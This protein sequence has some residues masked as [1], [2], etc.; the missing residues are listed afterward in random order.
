MVHTTKEF[1]TALLNDK[2]DWLERATITLE[3]GQVL[4]ITNEDIWQ[5]GF[6]IEDAISD[7]NTFSALGGVVI[8]KATLVLSNIYDKFSEYDFTYATVK[9]RVGLQL[10]QE[11]EMLDKGIYVVDNAIYNGSIITL[12]CYDYMARFDKP[13]TESTLQYP[14]TLDTIVRDACTTCKVPQATFDFPHKTF[15]VQ[16]RPDDEAVT[17]RSVLMWAAEIAGCFARIS[18]EGKLELAWFST[19]SSETIEPRLDGGT[20]DDGSPTY[21]SGD[22]ADGGSFNPWN[23]GD[24]YDVGTFED[25][26]TIHRINSTY[27]EDIATDDTVI[28]GVSILVKTKDENNQDALVEFRAGVEGFVI[29]IDDNDFLT[30]SNAQ[31]VADWLYEQLGGVRFR[32]AITQHPSDPSIEAGDMAILT[33]RKGN[34]YTMLVTRTVFSAGEAQTTASASESVPRNSA[35]RFTEA[36]KN[37]VALRKQVIKERTAREI[38]QEELAAAIAAKNG[39]YTTEEEGSGGGTTFYLHNHPNLSDSNIVWRMTADAFAVTNDYQGDETVWNAGLTVDGNLIANILSVYGINADWI[40]AGQLNI[41]D[42][43]GNETFFADTETGVVR[44]AASQFSLTGKTIPEIAQDSIEVGGRNLLRT[45]PKASNPTAYNAYQLNLVEK[46]VAGQTYTLQFWGIELDAG[47]SGIAVFWGGGG[48][49]IYNTAHLLH[50]DENGY[51]CATFTITEAQ[52]SH[53]QAANLWLNIY[54]VPRNHTGSSLTIE[55]WKLE[56]GNT[57]SD[58]TES[59]EDVF[60]YSDAQLN[61]FAQTVQA[62]I[63]DLQNQIDGVVDTYY[64]DYEPTVNNYPAHDWVVA[65]TE[66]EH[67]GDLFLDTS[68][69]KS[70]RWLMENNVWKWKEIPDTAAAQ[71]LQVAQHAQDTADGK[72]RVFVAQPTTEQAYDAGDLWVNATYG[73]TFSND[74]L[75]CVTPK[76]EGAAFN[77]NHWQL[78]SK[79]TDDSSLDAFIAGDYADDID[80]IGKQLDLR[81]QTYYQTSDPSTSWDTAAK[82]EHKGDLWYNSTSTV[83]KY[84]RWSGTAWQELT[85]TPPSAVVT[86]INNKGQIFTSEPVPPYARGDLWFGGATSDVLTCIKS[87]SSGSYVASDW[88]KL[89]KYTDDTAANQAQWTASS[90]LENANTA[91]NIAEAHYGTSDT[92]SDEQTKD[93]TCEGFTLYKGAQITVK[94]TNS[95]TSKYNVKLN[96][97]STGAKFVMNG[98]GKYVSAS[99][100]LYNWNTGNQRR[101]FVYDG[102]YWQMAPELSTYD[103]YLGKETTFNKLTDNGKQQAI[104]MDENGDLYINA[105]YIKAGVMSAELIS[106]GTLRLGYERALAGGGNIRMYNTNKSLVGWWDNTGLYIGDQVDGSVAQGWVEPNFAVLANGDVHIK[107]GSI[108]LGSGN[109]I[110]ASDGTLTIRKGSINIGSGKF[111]VSTAGALTATSATIT[112]AVYATSGTFGSASASKKITIGTNTSNASIYYGMSSLSSSSNGFYLGT[113]GIALGGGKFKVTSSGYAT[114]KG[115][116][117]SSGSGYYAELSPLGELK[118]G[119]GSSQYGYI[120]YAATGTDEPTGATL[121]GIQMQAT[122]LLR[123]SSPRISVAA[124]SNVSSTAY[125]GWNGTVACNL[126]SSGG[127]MYWDNRTVINGIIT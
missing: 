124:S 81:A 126:R 74:V 105:S 71:A 18:R 14:A 10:S 19:A 47:A 111:I 86:T 41:S 80:A 93:V 33:D 95:N 92:P 31:Q 27:S 48:N 26:S 23:V 101:T 51:I 5:G 110:A 82:A 120:D 91:R 88:K 40:N 117:R 1:K 4:N 49:G 6:T 29:Y 122:G 72:R 9:M 83:Q 76:A 25:Q 107:S 118:G 20:F 99:T 53:A 8:N 66:A 43:S 90:A 58:Y 89:N 127:T 63:Q 79:Y 44:I 50:P 69:G 55:K 70:Y 106:G 60:A 119:Y 109:F 73:S 7:D 13:Y 34:E 87:R 12:E 115:S 46:L 54:N 35:A 125:Y 85:A 32:K 38:A 78:A 42:T 113:D 98:A 123:I 67:E 45:T 59:P 103:K 16:S 96:V 62:E 68:T 121:H 104:K 21:T 39:L 112:G 15:V 30:T 75:R 100:D 3:D 2:R 36:T 84:Y 114:I 28:T 108:N 77:I 52:A 116:I 57:A 94:F 56:I 24:E 102:S 65:G 64:Y 22:T 61:T 37:Y 97:N 11:T 17:F